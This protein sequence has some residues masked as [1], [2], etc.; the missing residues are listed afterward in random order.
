M[1]AARLLLAA[2]V[3]VALV[4]CGCASSRAVP[5]AQPNWLDRLVT[6]DLPDT[7]DEAQMYLDG[8]SAEVSKYVA[9]ARIACTVDCAREGGC[10]D[11][12]KAAEKYRKQLVAL[13]KE[14]Q[15]GIDAWRAAGGEA[16]ALAV[17]AFLRLLGKHRPEFEALADLLRAWRT[18]GTGE[19]GGP[20]IP[21][22]GQ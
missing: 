13:K 5:P 14:V 2:L 22:G 8:A 16:N 1:K 3:A 17:E 12:C 20:I 19:D 18:G 10:S 7:P 15:G 11:E 4:A 9:L 21:G 6:G